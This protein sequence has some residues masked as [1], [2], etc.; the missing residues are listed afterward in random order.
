MRNWWSVVFVV[1][2]SALAACD[3]GGGGNRSNGIYAPGEDGGRALDR[4]PGTA[5]NV[6]LTP[7][8]TGDGWEVSTPAQQGMDAS[9]LESSLET[10]RANG[11]SGI[12]GVV[13]VRNDRLIAEAYYNGF[14]RETYHDVR[15]VTKSITSALAGI[16]IEQQLIVLEDPISQHI[17]KFDTYAN[18]DERKRAI[19]IID[20]LNMQTGLDCSDSSPS[21]P[22]NESKMYR[23]TDW[24][25]FV[26]DLPMLLPPGDT[27]SYC[28]G[29][30]MLLG[31]I[32]AMRSGMKVEDFAAT[33]L[34]GPLNITHVRWMHSPL[35]VTNANS[36]FQIRPR[37]AAKLGTLY[38]NAGLWK[39]TRVIPQ[40]WVE[41][42]HA[43]AGTMN[44]T[45]YGLLWWKSQFWVRGVLQD[46]IFASGNGG[47]F[48]FVLPQE[49]LVVVIAASNYGRSPLPSE[50][51]RNAILA[52]VQ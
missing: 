26:L 7:P 32:I 30:V 16:A 46:G 43:S 36:T 22:G 6:T 39:G 20:L 24:V 15:S 33:Y 11:S 25:K 31:H 2:C 14:D 41:Q 9:R 19:R 10:L 47:N 17:P 8:D 4:P 35:G 18:M 1:V 23:E 37:D 42:S 52:T 34:F 21:S 40:S 27:M 3:G 29:G 44:N 48:I 51:L 13:I 49:Q 12:D 45:H 28:S 38:L 50:N 5:A